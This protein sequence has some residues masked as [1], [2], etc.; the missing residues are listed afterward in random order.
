LPSQ[1]KA[2]ILDGI[3]QFHRTK[4]IQFAVPSHKRGKGI[5]PE[6]REFLG[7]K[8]FRNDLQ[9]LLG[10]DDRKE[11]HGYKDKAQDLAAKAYGADQCYFSTNGTSLSVHAAV[12]AVTKAGEK[13]I[14]PRNLH[15]SLAAALILGEVHPVFVEPAYDREWDLLHGVTTQELEKTLQEN[16]DAK[17]VF[18]VSPDYYGISADLKGLARVCHKFGKP[19]IVDEAWGPHFPFHPDL[20]MSAM[21]AGADLAMGS[22]HKTALG[23]GQSSIYLLQGK[24]ISHRRFKKA[25]DLFETTSPSSLIMASTDAARRQLVLHG[26]KDFGE[27]L[28]LARIARDELNMIPELRVL[29]DEKLGQKGIFDIDETKIAI[30]LRELGVSGFDAGDFLWNKCDLAIEL[31]DHRRLLAI[32]SPGDDEKSIKQLVSSIKKMVDWAKRRRKKSMPDLPTEDTLK[33]QLAMDP[34]KAYFANPKPVNIEDSVGCIAAETVSPYPPG[35]PRLIPGLLITQEIVDYLVKA[36][37][38]GMYQE[39]ADDEKLK[40]VLVVDTESH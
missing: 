19:L 29:G 23:L 14:V 40:K 35:I 3:K 38:A 1:R 21:E 13:V 15:R 34:M 18:V 39:D 31:S 10:V 32:V 22:M 6:I 33:F 11:S 4:K 5:D 7:E 12:L 26:K 8:T 17:A 20:P 24:R 36:R 16:P 30:D 9:I 28:R 37:D 2:P 27:A 25:F